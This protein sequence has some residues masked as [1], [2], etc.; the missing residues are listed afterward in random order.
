MASYL[1]KLHFFLLL[2]LSISVKADTSCFI[3][4]IGQVNCA[5]KLQS[6]AIIAIY[7]C[8]GYDVYFQKDKISYVL[9]RISRQNEDFKKGALKNKD[10]YNLKTFRLDLNFLNTKQEATIRFSNSI[11]IDKRYLTNQKKGLK[12]KNG[13]Q[14]LTYENVYEGIDLKFYFKEDKLK[15]DF[16]VHEG[17]DFNDIQME[18]AG[19]ESI[20]LNRLKLTIQT[21]L[22]NLEESIP[23]IYQGSNNKKLHVKG[24]YQLKDDVVSFQIGDYDRNKDL[25]I[26]PWSTFVGGVDIEECY[27]TF[28]DSK[29]NTYISGY[30]GSANFPVTV[31]ALE[32]TKEG[33]YDAFVT[34]LDT[35]GNVLW[36]TYYGGQGD[37]YGYGVL[38]DSDDNPY[39]IGHTTGNDLMISVNAYQ[40]NNNGSYDSFILKLDTAGGFI[41]ATYFGGSGGDLALAAS[42]DNLDNIVIGGYTSS[43]NMPAFNSFQNSMGGALDAFV[44]KFDSSGA[45]LWSTYCGGSN[46]E[47]VHTI[48]TD[49][50][51][52][53][54]ISGE[55]YSSDFP[56]STNAYQANNNGNL[57]VYLVKYNSN[58]GRIFSTYYGGTD[59]EDALGLATDNLDNIYLA[60]YSSSFDFPIIGSNIYQA[61]KSGG[62]DAFVVK[63]TPLGDPIKSTFIGGSNDD[64]FTSAII[65]SSNALYLAGYTNSLDIPLLG[66]AYQTVNNGLADGMYYKLDTALTP[67][68]STYIGGASADY[69]YD[70]KI[71]MTQQ[72]T[73]A[74]FTSSGDFPISSGVFQETIAG[75]SDAFVFQSDSIF[76][77]A[78]GI[79]NL[80]ISSLINVY[81]NP[82]LALFNVSINDFNKESEYQY[83]IYSIEGK[84][85]FRDDIYTKNTIIYWGSEM[86]AG[87][88]VLTVM[89][90]SGIIGVIKLIKKE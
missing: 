17:A 60:G 32:I 40:A 45:L 6:E 72:L 84:V 36:S 90:N 25:I 59:G 20:Q 15:Y 21:P 13:F 22:G 51:N 43:A 23:E 19:E 66:T 71:D 61:I 89:K 7:S 76:N 11:L 86:K 38:V 55:T 65:S 83:S 2:A 42:I 62:R 14:E 57:D 4:N 48:T 53:V 64:R 41:W 58:G 67:N 68:Y 77:V 74:G 29:N 30:T 52:N 88:Y 50:Q 26:D 5:D 10:L 31:G 80:F 16:I 63:F 27:S 1:R 9:K 34:K 3:K 56:T 8:E 18:Y 39:L 35:T 12:I 78:T 47:D 28:L 79:Y 37:E 73:F 82:S 85:M 33:L 44:A 46:S 87:N 70:L 75:Q 49:N 69:I 81:P 54:L 24:N